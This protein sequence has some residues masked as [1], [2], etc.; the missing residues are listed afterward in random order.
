M[1]EVSPVP[2]I[3]AKTSGQPFWVKLCIWFTRPHEIIT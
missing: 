2:L 3:N 1:G